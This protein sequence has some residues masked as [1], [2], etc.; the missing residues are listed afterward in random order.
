MAMAAK[1]QPTVLEHPHLLLC[2]GADAKY[3]LIWLL[4]YLVDSEGEMPGYNNFQV[5]DYGG[6][7]ELQN[8]LKLLPSRPGFADDT[9]TVK[10][11]TIIRDAETDASAAMQSVCNALRKCNFSVPPAPCKIAAPSDNHHNVNV[12]YALFPT[13]DSFTNGT[14]EDLCLDTLTSARKGTILNIANTAVSSAAQ[15]SALS[16]EHKNQLHTYLSLTNEYVGLKIGESAKANAF[17][18]SSGSFCPLKTLLKTIS[19]E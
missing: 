1:N 12:A 5:D 13:F 9:N 4:Q 7:T 17:D 10:S 3:F 15:I 2:E 16:R 18:F 8:Y 6:I 19:N 14:L 11:I